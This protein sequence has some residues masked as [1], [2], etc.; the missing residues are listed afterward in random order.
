MNEL[1]IFKKQLNLVELENKLSELPQVEIPIMHDFMG[2][3]YLRR[4]FAPKDTL[5]IGKRH[6]N[7]TCNILLSGKLSVY[8]GPGESVK[9]I[10]GP[11]IFKSEAGAKKMGYTHSD[12]IFLNIHPT[13]ETDL[14]KIE[15]EFIIPEDEYIEQQKIIGEGEICPG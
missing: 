12:V 1:A 7:E 9:H 11:C 4:M 5:I 10:E 13:E 2:G 3:V 15:Q 6:R 14:D 8:V